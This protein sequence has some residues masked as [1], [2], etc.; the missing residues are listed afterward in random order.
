MAAYECLAELSKVMRILL[1]RKAS[2]GSKSG[3]SLGRSKELLISSQALIDAVKQYN[4][5][6]Y[7]ADRQVAVLEAISKLYSAFHVR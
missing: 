1:E 4:Y 5:E 7:A 3:A 6:A 2:P